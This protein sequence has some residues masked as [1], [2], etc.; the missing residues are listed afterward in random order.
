MKTEYK[1]F[2]LQSGHQIITEIVE[3]PDQDVS[4]EL[5]CRNPMQM[6][7]IAYDEEKTIHH[8]RP[9]MID[10]CGEKNLVTICVDMIVGTAI[11]TDGSIKHYIET[12]T[13]YLE[14]KIV[15]SEEAMQTLLTEE[16]VYT[17]D[18][19]DK[20]TDRF[21]VIDGDFDIDPSKLN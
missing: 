2:Q 16:D 4:L 8:M 7:S 10:Q 6:Y 5:V 15:T 18:E 19:I 14:H 13:H 3:W 20:A 1:Q 11:P 17:G 21:N 9:W 12:V